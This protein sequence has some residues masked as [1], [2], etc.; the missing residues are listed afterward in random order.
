MSLNPKWIN[1]IGIESIKDIYPSYSKKC[2]QDWSLP[3]HE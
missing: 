2:P 3:V 1:L